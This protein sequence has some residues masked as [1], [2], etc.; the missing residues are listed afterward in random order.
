MESE[1]PGPADSYVLWTD[2]PEI[3]K[4]EGGRYVHFGW[5]TT[6][7]GVVY[8]VHDLIAGRVQ[9]SSHAN[10]HIVDY[11]VNP[12]DLTANAIWRGAKHRIPAVQARGLGESDLGSIDGNWTGWKAVLN[13]LTKNPR[14]QTRIVRLRDM[15]SSFGLI[16]SREST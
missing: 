3:V 4:G 8:V 9:L 6:E 13:V 14:V 2:L 10:V 5:Q 15:H 12:I 11:D 16:S 1:L 7:D